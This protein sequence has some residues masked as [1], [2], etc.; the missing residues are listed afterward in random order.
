V[1]DGLN[2]L[3][4]YDGSQVG[5]DRVLQLTL[6]LLER[7]GMEVENDPTAFPEL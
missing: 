7:S 1:E 5:L 4:N 6:K 3:T 2:S